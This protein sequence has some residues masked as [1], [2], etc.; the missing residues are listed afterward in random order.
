MVCRKL[1]L[2]LLLILSV[3][4]FCTGCMAKKKTDISPKENDIKKAQVIF[5]KVSTPKV[6]KKTYDL[7]SSTPYELSL[8]SIMEISKLPVEVKKAID[9]LLE[10]SQG[11]YLL[12]FEENK[13][14][15]IL[16][17]P[18]AVSNTFIRHDLQFAEIFLDGKIVYHNAGYCGFDGES[19]GI[20]ETNEEDWIFDDSSEVAR[21]LKHTVFNEKGKIKFIESW[22]YDE[23]E[24]IKYQMKNAHKKVISILKES[25]DNDSNLRK[26]HVFYDNDGNIKMSLSVNYE[27]ANISRCTF[28][29]SHDS[30]DSISVFGE[31]SGGL[32]TKE[33]IYNEE[34]ELINT[35]TAEYE[36]GVRKTITLFDKDGNEI[37]KISS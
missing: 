28:Y 3:G 9:S 5:Q 13:V 14:L 29:N 7:Y 33:L 1:T 8:Y 11:F 20:Y 23:K 25:Q 36:D 24:P 17:N 4:L 27:G 10:S 35:L 32:K 22:N 26:E 15:V 16:Q 37:N 18:V 19:L 21:P 12:K 31:Y 6:V 30:V 34:Y 2:S